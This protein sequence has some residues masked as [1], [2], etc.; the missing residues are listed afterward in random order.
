MKTAFAE[1]CRRPRRDIKFIKKTELNSNDAWR[2]VSVL[3][4]RKLVDFTMVK[5]GNRTVPFAN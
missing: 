1:N 5:S 2:M 3:K 4:E